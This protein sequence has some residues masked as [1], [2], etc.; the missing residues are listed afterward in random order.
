MAGRLG[1]RPDEGRVSAA[2]DLRRGVRRDA[3]AGRRGG[4]RRRRRLRPRSCRRPRR[5][6]SPTAARC[7]AVLDPRPTRWSRPRP[8]RPGCRCRGR[9]H[10][11]VAGGDDAD[12]ARASPR[13][14]RPG[15]RLDRHFY[16]RAKAAGRP[17]RGLE[18]AAYQIDRLDGLAMPVQVEMLRA[19]LDDVDTQVAAVGADRRRLAHRRRAALERLLLKEFRES[20]RSTSACSSSATATW[21]AADRELRRRAG[22]LPGR[23]RRRAPLGP[24]SVVAM[25]RQAGFTVD[26][27]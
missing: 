10:E 22:A 11:A 8:T 25:L 17:V 19:A 16:D 18:T 27:Q 23:R 2:R 26:Q 3:N 20:R 12:R 15:I 7:S 13:R 24:D 5:R 4:P 1:A 9:A 14:V 6:C 21:I